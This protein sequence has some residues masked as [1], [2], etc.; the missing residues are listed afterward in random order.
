MTSIGFYLS[1][2]IAAGSFSSA[3]AFC[4]HLQQQLRLMAYRLAPSR[5]C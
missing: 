4:R 3:A 5:I 1:G 2:L